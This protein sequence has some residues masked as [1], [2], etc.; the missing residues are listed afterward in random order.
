MR[1]ITYIKN[2]HQMQQAKEY[3]IDEII[4]EH[5]EL[6]RFGSLSD[7]KFCELA[8][9]AKEL[10][11]KVLMEWDV[12]MTDNQFKAK[13]KKMLQ[14]SSFVD[15]IRV[16]DA[17][18]MQSVFTHTKI[19]MQLILENG[20]HNLKGVQNWIELFNDKDKRVERVVLSIELARDTLKEYCEKLA[21]PIE[22]LV[23]GRIPLFYTPRSLLTPLVKN[24][25]L[26]QTSFIEAIGE[27]EESPHKGFPIIENRHGTFMFH[28]RHFFLL[29]YLS[30]LCEI[31]VNSLRIDLRFDEDFDYLD[32][33]MEVMSNNDLAKS[34]K[35]TYPH[36]VI[37]GFYHVNRS[38][39][40]F[41][42]LKNHRIQRKDDSGGAEFVGEVVDVEKDGHMAIMIKANANLRVDDK[43]KF[44]TPE[45][46]EYFCNVHY[47]QNSAGEKLAIAKK[48]QLVLMN[49]YKGVWTKSIVYK[50]I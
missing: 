45:G 17:G 43:L 7:E 20:N 6:A 24:E 11:L 1:N 50:V 2:K 9:L 37:R 27:S 23:L 21:I 25:P 5:F 33:V 47:L 4:L 18:A 28:I 46:K 26:A 30:D 35:K 32:S 12:L 49:R 44:I 15:S 8:T 40:L 3:G 41:K 38:D 48:D 19:P 13:E 39:V 10:D 36:D 16:Q 29:D 42:K 14:L 22:F 34:F 31:G